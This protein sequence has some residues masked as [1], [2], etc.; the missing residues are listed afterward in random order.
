LRL[1]LSLFVPSP[2]I[3]EEEGPVDGHKECTLL[4]LKKIFNCLFENN[5]IFDKAFCLKLG[6]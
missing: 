2:L 3:E 6:R 4:L 5:H 1:S